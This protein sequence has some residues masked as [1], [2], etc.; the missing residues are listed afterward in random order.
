[1]ADARYRAPEGYVTMTEAT[2]I[3]GSSRPAA[4]RRIQQAGLKTYR[5][6]KDPRARLL[7]REDVEALASQGLIEES[8]DTKR[9]A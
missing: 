7:R 1:M 3:L 5:D 9:A 6:P 8:A 2:E 4:R